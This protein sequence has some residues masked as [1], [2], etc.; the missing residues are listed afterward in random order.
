L[1]RKVRRVK[2]GKISFSHLANCHKL[3]VTFENG[4]RREGEGKGREGNGNFFLTLLELSGKEEE[5]E[6]IEKIDGF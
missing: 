3:D 4:G 1:L 6:N 5:G 2:A